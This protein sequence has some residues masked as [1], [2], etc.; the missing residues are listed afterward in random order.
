MMATATDSAVFL[1][2]DELTLDPTVHA[3]ASIDEATAAEYAEAM[4]AGAEFPPLDVFHDGVTYWLADGFTRAAGAA[5]AGKTG[6]ACVVH[7]GGRREAFIHSLRV[8][9]AHGLRFSNADKRHA[10]ARL[11]ADAEWAAK[12]D[13]W[14]AKQAGVSHP[15]VGRLRLELEPVTSCGQPAPRTGMDGKAR[16]APTRREPI[17]PA[18][19]PDQGPVAEQEPETDSTPEVPRERPAEPNVIGDAVERIIGFAEEEI[20]WMEPHQRAAVKEIVASRLCG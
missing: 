9:R 14:I 5:D 19:E 6:F 4:R 10:V 7:D 16:S 1:V 20:R 17:E 13:R 3:R 2:F 15:F 8:N 12:S 11:L 18:A